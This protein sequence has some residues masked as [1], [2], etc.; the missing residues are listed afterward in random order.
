MSKLICLIGPSGVGK[1]TLRKYVVKN[2][3]TIDYL[4]SITTRTPREKEVH[5]EDYFFVSIEE[6]KE[7]I[8]SNKLLE[9]E[10]H[11]GHYYGISKDL[12]EKKLTAGISLI[13]EIGI[14]GYQ[15]IL[16]SVSD[17]KSIYS[18]FLQPESLVDLTQRIKQRGDQ[19]LD[20]RLKNAE[21]ELKGM[22]L[23]HHTI[24]VRQG[25]LNALQTEVNKIIDQQINI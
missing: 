25:Q 6:F 2:Y 5:G 18:I 13:K 23:C 24:V 1:T 9:W 21:T 3:P 20:I 22:E 11:F 14:G 10:E 7:L 8:T 16:K 17:V 19:D 15:Q 12:F 4:P